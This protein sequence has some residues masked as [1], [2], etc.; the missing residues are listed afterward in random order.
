[1]PKAKICIEV[2]G[3]KDK[4]GKPEVSIVAGVSDVPF[5]GDLNAPPVDIEVPY[6]VSV[7]ALAE[8]LKAVL[9]DAGDQAVDFL[10]G[11]VQE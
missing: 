3:D 11:L 9:P 10:L 5:F 2:G 7:K 6:E 8:L 4:D 1:M